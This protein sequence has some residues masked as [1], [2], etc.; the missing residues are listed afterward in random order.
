M[1]YNGMLN[2]PQMASRIVDPEFQIHRTCRWCNNKLVRTAAGAIICGGFC[3]MP[4]LEDEDYGNELFP[5][6]Q[7]DNG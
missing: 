6:R 3:D 1:P 2:D 5:P 7:E 4:D